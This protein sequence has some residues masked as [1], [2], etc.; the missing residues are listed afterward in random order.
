MIIRTLFAA[1]AVVALGI[2]VITTVLPTRAA[3]VTT[4]IQTVVPTDFG[5]TWDIL[6][7]GLDEGDFTINATITEN[8]MIR[9]LLQSKTPSKWVDC[10]SLTVS[11]KHK[12]FGDRHYDF[13]AAN[14]V[15]YLVADEEFD[16]L[17]DVERRTSLNALANIK[18]T[19]M[20][21]G[22]KVSVDAH[23]VMKFRTREFG[24]KITPRFLDDS[25]DFSS[26][27][28]ASMTEEI[29]QGAKM[30]VS[31]INCRPTGELERR[32]V[33]VVERQTARLTP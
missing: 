10:G 24:R 23:Y 7:R 20:K 17:I 29:R 28:Q 26:A 32:I 12:I 1:S 18:L 22:T 27:S 19:P 15:R 13:L 8:S 21:H 11:S 6:V 2:S 30:K 3:G 33:S 9:V 16:E 4:A 25:L 14:S 5:T 31:T